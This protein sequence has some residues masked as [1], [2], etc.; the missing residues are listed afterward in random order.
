MSVSEEG[1]N[2]A[3]AKGWG[4]RKGEIVI[5]LSWL[6]MVLVLADVDGGKGRVAS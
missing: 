6:V 5:P 4:I 1:E 3:A 2:C